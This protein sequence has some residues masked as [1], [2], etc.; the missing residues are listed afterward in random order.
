MLRQGGRFICIVMKKFKL[1]IIAGIIIVTW[2]LYKAAQP[3]PFTLIFLDVGQGDAELIKTPD[4]RIILIDGGPDASVIRKLGQELPWTTRTI[5]LVVVSHPHAD[6][7]TGLIEVLK[8]YKVNNILTSSVVY[9]TPEYAT[10]LALI[11]KKHIPVIVARAGQTIGI[12]SGAT[13][14]VILPLMSYQDQTIDNV[15]TSM[16][17]NSLRYGKTTAL[18]MGDAE[19]PL[20]QSLVELG[21]DLKSD[22]LKVGHHG[23]Q[24]S[25][26]LEFIKAV[27]PQYAV[28]SVGGKNRYG[29][30]HPTVLT[31]LQSLVPQVLRTDTEGDIRFVSN[32]QV[33]AR[34]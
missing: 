3:W 1:L 17:V 20:E 28:I 31:R 23:S 24:T 4:H 25:S 10:W 5:D 27:A 9:N 6:H 15:H 12:G 8:R 29:H 7:V 13:L 19:V 22:I 11:N 21:V 26:S 16:V 33:W 32:E 2:W 18:F 14:T 34:Q 30:P